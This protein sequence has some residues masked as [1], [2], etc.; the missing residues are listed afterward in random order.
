MGLPGKEVKSH[1]LNIRTDTKCFRA[2]EST[3]SDEVW[4]FFVIVLI[5]TSKTIQK[6]QGTIMEIRGPDIVLV[7]IWS[8]T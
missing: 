3:L 1:T 2:S 8:R 4:N 7:R 6:R 5:L